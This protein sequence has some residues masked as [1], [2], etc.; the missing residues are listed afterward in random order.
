MKTEIMR[1]NVKTGIRKISI[2]RLKSLNYDILGHN[3]E[4]KKTNVRHYM[5]KLYTYIVKIMTF[6]CVEKGLPY[7]NDSSSAVFLYLWRTFNLMCSHM[8][9]YIIT[10]ALIASYPIR[11]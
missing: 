5:R 3:Y 6:F 9:T 11:I 4:I 2:L 10:I 1:L 7:I 8:Y